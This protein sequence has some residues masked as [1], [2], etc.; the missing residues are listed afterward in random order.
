MKITQDISLYNFEAWSGAKETKEIIL[1][2]NKESEFEYLIE[3]LYPEGI[4]DTQLNDLL[5]FDSE[6][7]YESLGIN[8]SDS[9]FTDDEERI[10]YINNELDNATDIMDTIQDFNEE[11][12]NIY[13]VDYEELYTC[14][15][16][17][18]EEQEYK[19]EID[20]TIWNLF[21]DNQDYNYLIYTKDSEKYNI[22][23]AR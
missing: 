13:S 23:I 14:L 17:Y 3:E 20:D 11:D 21:G 16:D 8:E 4:T 10:E 1:N 18:F 9:D 15:E 2:N 7:I 22:I 12:Y 6:Q 19:D 5:W